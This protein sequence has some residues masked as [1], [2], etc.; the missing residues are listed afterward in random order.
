MR[1]ECVRWIGWQT[2]NQSGWARISS[3]CCRAWTKSSGKSWYYIWSQGSWFYLYEHCTVCLLYHWH[4]QISQ[5]VL[6][7]WENSC[8][9]ERSSFRA[10]IFT[11]T[12]CWAL[13]IWYC[14][15]SRFADEADHVYVYKQ[16]TGSQIDLPIRSVVF[17]FTVPKVWSRFFVCLSYCSILF[18]E[19]PSGTN[20]IEFGVPVWLVWCKNKSRKDWSLPFQSVTT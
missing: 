16:W 14:D 5:V 20:T 3:D 4:S 13:Y 12:Y 11:S 8:R 1:P 7:H 2:L 10:I 18:V 9:I 19:K 15:L 17:Y 6:V